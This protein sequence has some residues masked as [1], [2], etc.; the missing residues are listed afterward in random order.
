MN[1][2][3]SD[4]EEQLVIMAELVAE[5]HEAAIEAD[6]QEEHA[7]EDGDEEQAGHQRGAGDGQLPDQGEPL[8][9]L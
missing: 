1:S 3:I 8:D 2:I 7:E 9:H 5:D 6:L 4:A